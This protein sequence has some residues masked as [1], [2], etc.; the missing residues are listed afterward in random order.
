MRSYDGISCANATGGSQLEMDLTYDLGDK[1]SKTLKSDLLEL[2]SPGGL[3]KERARHRSKNYA[4]SFHN[5][6]W[7]TI[8]ICWERSHYYIANGMTRLQVSAL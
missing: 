8:I 5:L 7:L 6:V 4:F 2:D 1:V 3:L